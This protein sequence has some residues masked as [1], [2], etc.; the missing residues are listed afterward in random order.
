MASFYLITITEWLIATVSIYSD[1]TRLTAQ[2]RGRLANID[3]KAVKVYSINTH[4]AMNG[5][6]YQS[7]SLTYLQY[8]NSTAFVLVIEMAILLL[9][10]RTLTEKNDETGGSRKYAAIMMPFDPYELQYFHQQKSSE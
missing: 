10:I 1:V 3:S 8:T 6:A 9:F 5:K 4:P 7:V 2:G